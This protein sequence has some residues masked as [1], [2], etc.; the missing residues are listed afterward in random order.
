[1]IFAKGITKSFGYFHAL[2]NIDLDIKK[3][4]FLVIFGPNGA[5]KTTLLN[6]L[7][8]MARPSR[9]LIKID[10][11]D[12]KESP[13]IIRR[14]I[15]VISHQ[16]FLYDDLTAYENLYFYGKL[17][18]VDKLESR[19]SR[20][21]GEVE[22]GHRKNDRVRTFSRG[23]KQRLAIARSTLHD[24]AILLMDEPYTGLDQRAADLLKQQLEKLSNGDRTII[25][26][27]HDITRGLETCDSVAILADGEIRFMELKKNIDVSEFKLIYEKYTNKRR[28]G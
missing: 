13:E 5:G 15:G 21:L 6:I 10:G 16:T 11:A 12:T 7:S 1:M 9:G 20:T 23:M 26:A 3:G 14:Q 17:Y 19:I 25:M 24:P 18:N 22:L 8:T 27:T 4:S 2:K 28:S